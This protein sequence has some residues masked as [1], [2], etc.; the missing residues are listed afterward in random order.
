M[1]AVDSIF[2]TIIDLTNR[3]FRASIYTRELLD[4][5]ESGSRRAVWRVR[6]IL[7]E[8]L[9]FLECGERV[10]S[11]LVVSGQGGSWDSQGNHTVDEP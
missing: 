10:F 8:R 4:P 2:I 3:N 7:G 11:T 6:M 5:A 9:N 1:V